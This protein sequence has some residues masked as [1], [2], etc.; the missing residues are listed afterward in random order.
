MKSLRKSLKKFSDEETREILQYYEEM[1]D[2]QIDQGCLE[3]EA[4]ADLGNIDYISSEIKNDL[5]EAR[6]ANNKSIKR[7]WSNFSIVLVS[8]LSPA[9]M[10][11]AIAFI[12]VFLSLFITIYALALAFGATSVG[13]IIGI[14]PVCIEG[15]I[16]FGAAGGFIFAGIF[17]I[18]IC[19]FAFLSVI[20]VYG[21]N[22]LLNK[23]IRLFIKKRKE[24]GGK[25]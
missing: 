24:K 10:P 20:S 4:V 12:A 3:S 11:L 9:L 6:I 13:L 14:V 5:V 2:E 19:I 18:L 15:V 1:I 17:L 8:L 21:G 7:T 16:Q 23:I 22:K 25:K